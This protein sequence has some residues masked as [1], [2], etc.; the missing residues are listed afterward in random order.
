LEQWQND[1]KGQDMHSGTCTNT[2]G[3]CS[4]ARWLKQPKQARDM[5]WA[6]SGLQK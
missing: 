2:D 6:S 3:E 1:T 5:L 4:S